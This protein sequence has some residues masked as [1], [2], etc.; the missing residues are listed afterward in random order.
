MLTPSTVGRRKS[1]GQRWLPIRNPVNGH[2]IGIHM[3]RVAHATGQKAVPLACPVRPIK[4]PAKWRDVH[5]GHG[6][7]GVQASL[8]QG[9]VA[10][11]CVDATVID[12]LAG[13]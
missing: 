10:P 2:E 1:L 13:T 6:C 7:A 11:G 5:F 8:C 3:M 9:L 12:D 4:G